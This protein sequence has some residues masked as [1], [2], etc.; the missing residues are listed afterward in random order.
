MTSFYSPCIHCQSS[1]KIATISKRAQRYYTKSLKLFEAGQSWGAKPKKPVPHRDNCPHC[2][3]SGLLPSEYFPEIDPHFPHVAI[4]G[5]GIGGMALAL[6]CLH[7]GI[8]YTL[9]EKDSS[10]DARSQGYGLT[11]QQAS[12]ALEWLGIPRF[13]NGIT[14]VMHIVHD[15]GGKI[16]GEWGRRRLKPEE[17]EKITKRRNVHIPRQLLRSELRH[18]LQG[19][20]GV[21]WGYILKN[22]SQIPSWQYGLE[23]DVFGEKKIHHADLVVGAD[24]IYSSVRSCILWEEKTPLR[25]L[26]CIVILGICPLEKLSEHSLLDGET[27]FQSVDGVQ[28]IYMMPYDETHIMWQFSYPLAKSDAKLLS[29][30]WP[31]ALKQDILERIWDW[32]NPIPE[33][34]ECTPITH[35]TGYPVYDRDILTSEDMKDLWDITFIGDAMHPMSPFKGQG[36]N[37]A[38]LDALELARDIFTKCGPDSQW[39]EK[40]LRKTVL[41]DFETQMLK[42]SALKVQDSARQAQLLHS[43]AV[44]HDGDMPRG[45]G[46]DGKSVL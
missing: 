42:R 9:Y 43:D 22:I 11:L 26:G 29:K 35:I 38:I 23:F 16:I 40:W 18:G 5:G 37:Q 46:I 13:K 8:P 6:A 33:I 7:R 36:A 27:V 41:E 30:E 10:F 17:L 31:E 45:R 14:S 28:R 2:Q 21:L 4:I 24:G 44:L 15:Q 20:R 12:K 3:G 1:W 39:R 25:Y 32:H 34:L 19:D